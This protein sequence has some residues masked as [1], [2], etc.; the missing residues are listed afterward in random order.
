M[1]EQLGIDFEGS[2]DKMQQQAHGPRL[3][4]IF[5]GRALTGQELKEEGMSKVTRKKQARIYR[6]QLIEG[7]RG[8]PLGSRITSENLTAFVGRPPEG[9]N[10]SA[11]GPAF[12]Y[13]AKAGMIRKTGRWIKARR[14]ERHACELPEWLVLAYHPRKKGQP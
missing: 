3:G 11:V 10:P 5:A 14:K 8:F 6:D 2:L 13:M 1:Y 12:N 4:V 9:V 7:L